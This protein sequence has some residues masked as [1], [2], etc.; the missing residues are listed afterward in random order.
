MWRMGSSQREQLHKSPEAGTG[1]A[2]LRNSKSQ[3]GQQGLNGTEV[4]HSREGGL[5]V[6]WGGDLTLR[7]L[8]RLLCGPRILH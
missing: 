6:G 5:G 2:H 1:Q 4:C 7:S 8:C 3:Q